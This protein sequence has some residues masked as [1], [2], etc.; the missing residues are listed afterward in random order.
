MESI[1]MGKLRLDIKSN[2]ILGVYGI[3]DLVFNGV[4]IESN[5]Q[6]TTD[7]IALEYDVDILTDADNTLKVSLLNDRAHD[8]NQD[9]VFDKFMTV[10]VTALSYSADGVNF[11][12]LL[13]Q[14]ATSY[15]VPDGLYAGNVLTLTESVTSFNSLGINYSIAFNSDGIV[16][17]TLISG[18]LG[19]VD[20]SNET[21]QDLVT[22]ITYDRFR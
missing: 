3:V 21:Y 1:F 16:N 17:S 8:A 5:K 11:T 18:V 2:D 19:K 6:L 10:S 7:P 20:L 15:T 9:G 12:T 22:G 4:A 14:V 13:P